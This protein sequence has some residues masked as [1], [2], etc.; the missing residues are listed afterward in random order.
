MSLL[1]CYE[2]FNGS[3]ATAPSLHTGSGFVGDLSSSPPTVFGGT[4]LFVKFVSS[5]I[6]GNGKFKFEFSIGK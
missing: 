1:L 3:V 5:L 4:S 6:E 2:V